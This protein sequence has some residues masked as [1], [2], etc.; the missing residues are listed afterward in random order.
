GDGSQKG[1]YAMAITATDDGNNHLVLRSDDYGNSSFTIDQE[2]TGG[3]SY[4]HIIYT[5]AG[6]TV[7]STIDD[8]DTT[9]Y[10]T[11]EAG[12]SS[13]TTWENIYGATIENLDQITISGKARDG[14]TDISGLY[15]INDVTTDTVDGLLTAIQTAYDDEGTTV[16]V[17]IRDG[18]IYVEDTTTGSSAIELTL[19]YATIEGLDLGTFTETTERDMDLGLIN[20]TVTGLDVVGTIDGEDATGSGRVLTGDDGNTNT[21]GL[22]IRYSGTANDTDVGTITLTLGVAEL[23]ERA[24]YNITDSIDG[25]AAF[26]QDSLQNRIEDFEDQIEQMEAFLD[27]KMET[28]I[29]RFVAMEMALSKIQSQSDWL[30][31]QISASFSGW[32]L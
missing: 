27:R 28:M 6:N 9:V 17:F 29:N 16:D 25:Y 24:L 5:T 12:E 11:G 26:R 23:F 32:K 30:A 20:G 13:G 1:R 31:G 10:I 21:D 4:D 7:K 14:I 15:T 8:T 22:S 18:K 3:S 2:I 19:T